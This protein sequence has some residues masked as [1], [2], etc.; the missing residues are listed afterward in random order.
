VSE[1]VGQT[2]AAMKKL[3]RQAGLGKKQRRQLRD[4]LAALLG[5]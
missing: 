2:P 1:P 4:R 5:R 3:L